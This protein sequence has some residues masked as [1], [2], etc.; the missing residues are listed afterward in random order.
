[1]FSKHRAQP[2]VELGKLGLLMFQYLDI[3]DRLLRDLDIDGLP[4]EVKMRSEFCVELL[5]LRDAGIWHRY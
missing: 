5:K 3:P 2:T 1:M 4:P